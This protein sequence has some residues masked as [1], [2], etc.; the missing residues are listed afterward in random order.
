MLETLYEYAVNPGQIVKFINM[1]FEARR[2]IGFI[3]CLG[4]QKLLKRLS[5]IEL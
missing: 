3:T 5:Q 1:C 2:T 4:L